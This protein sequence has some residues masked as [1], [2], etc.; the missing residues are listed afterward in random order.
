MNRKW[1]TLLTRA[2][3]GIVVLFNLQCSVVFLISSSVFS[4]SFE[5]TGIQ[6]A[7]MIRGLGILFLMWTV[8][9]FFALSDPVG[10]RVSL[11]E[12]VIMEGIGLAGESLLLLTLPAGHAILRETAVRFIGFD[13][14]GLILLLAAL[15][16][17]VN[18][19]HNHQGAA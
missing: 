6:G 5:L 17:S 11:I 18:L 15:Y 8:P 14:G 13:G 7:L 19:R 1:Q 2:L 10:R 12:A 16:L 9:Y 4:P 3:I